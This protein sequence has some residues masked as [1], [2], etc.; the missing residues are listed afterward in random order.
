MLFFLCLNFFSALKSNYVSSD[1]ETFRFNLYILMPWSNFK[2]TFLRIR[3][4]G[5]DTLSGEQ[6]CLTFLPPFSKSIYGIECVLLEAK[7]SFQS[8]PHFQKGPVVPRSKQQVQTRYF[9]NKC[10]KVYQTLPSFLKIKQLRKDVRKGT[11]DMCT[12]RKFRSA[13]EFSESDQSHHWAHLG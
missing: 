1:S 2:S 5:I 4:S 9:A 10:R 12:Q 7:Y 6:L 8:M 11:F 13:C 3:L